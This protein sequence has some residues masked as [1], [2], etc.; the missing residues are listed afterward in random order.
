MVILSFDDAITD[1]T[2]N[3]YK[4]LF[5]GRH[6][7]PNGCAIKGTFFISH[8]WNNY[9]QTQWLYGQGHEIALNSITHETLANKSK[10]RWR[11]EMIGLK[12]SLEAFSYVDKESIKGVRAPQLL[13]GGDA[14]FQMMEE[15]KLW[16]DNSM[17]VNEGPLWPQT[18]DHSLS[19]DCSGQNCPRRPHKGIWMVPLQLLQAN[20]GIWHNTARAA[21]K[22]TDSR[23]SVMQFLRNNFYRNYNT[24]RAPFILTADTD[25]LTYLPDNGVVLAINDWLTEVGEQDVYV[26]TVKQVI[27]W[28]QTPV[29]LSEASKFKPW[30]CE[31]RLKDHMQPCEVM[32]AKLPQNIQ[33]SL[34]GNCGSIWLWV[35]AL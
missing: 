29:A 32:S 33:G 20:N 24:N 2:I 4:S 21:L 17:P 35:Q 16:Y 30:Q 26:V 27:S 25:F 14:Q 1:R 9:D 6:R 15:E 10:E 8:Q 3:V 28:M 5:N 34:P 13:I 18:L 11:H 23:S 19:W 12:E 31:R 7:N 22:P